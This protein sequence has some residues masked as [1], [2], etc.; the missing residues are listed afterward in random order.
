MNDKRLYA[1]MLYLLVKKYSK[2]ELLRII[3]RMYD[4]EIIDGTWLMKELIG[5]MKN[6][7]INKIKYYLPIIA[8]SALWF[9]I[10]IGI[11]IGW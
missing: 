3:N 11:L 4:E 8:A 6:S 9:L 2:E 7:I 5:L 1:F 10:C